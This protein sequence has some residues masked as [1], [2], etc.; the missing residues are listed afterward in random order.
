MVGFPGACR[1]SPY[2][3][4]CILVCAI[5]IFSKPAARNFS[6][7]QWAARSIS[8]LCSLLVLT[9]GIRRNSF[10]SFKFSSRRDS[11]YS[12][13]FIIAGP[14]VVGLCRPRQRFPRRGM[15]ALYLLAIKQ[16]LRFYGTLCDFSKLF[17]GCVFGNFPGAHG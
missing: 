3:N 4:G 6:A 8:G 11:I 5:S 16:V 10:S 1:D 7:T 15:N 9:L 14:Q 17:A 13:S 2:T 12:I